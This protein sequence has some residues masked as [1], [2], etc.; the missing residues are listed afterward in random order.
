MGTD[1]DG[2]PTRVIAE[3]DA[4]MRRLMA[5]ILS[6]DG[7]EIVETRDGLETL[8]IL[9]RDGTSALILNLVM[10][11][12]SGWAVLEERA[13]NPALGKVPVI[14]VSAKRGPDIARALA[15]GVFGLLPKPFDPADL[16][17]LV[18]T[19]VNEMRAR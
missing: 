2:G 17:D 19:C 4:S 10:P 5:R 3:D 13:N 12:L 11:G 16:R 9:R 7:Y 6:N 1:Y 15:Y 8:E 18:K 14:V